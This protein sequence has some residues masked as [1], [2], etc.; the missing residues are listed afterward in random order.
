MVGGR[1]SS[2]VGLVGWLEGWNWWEGGR[3]NLCGSDKWTCIQRFRV[4][5]VGVAI[6]GQKLEKEGVVEG[7]KEG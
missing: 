6:G 4:G 5:V 1:E 3:V 7:R 2:T